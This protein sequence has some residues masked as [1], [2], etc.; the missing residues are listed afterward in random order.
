[1]DSPFAYDFSRVRIQDG[2]AASER[3]AGRAFEVSQPDDHAERA[4]EAAAEAVTAATTAA[5]RPD[6][7][8]RTPMRPGSTAAG[9]PAG[10]SAGLASHGAPLDAI[11]RDEMESKFGFDFGQVRV[12]TDS[13]AARSAAAVSARAYTVGRDVVFGADQ[14]APQTA[15]GQRLLAHELAHTVQQADGPPRLNR[16]V[17]PAALEQCVAELGGS[18]SY[19]DGGIAQ[20]EELERYRKECQRRLAPVAPA[21]SAIDNLL[22]AW[23]YAKPQLKPE[24]VKEVEN[25]FTRQSIAAMAAFAALYAGAQFTP[26]GWIAD[27]FALTLLT[28]TVI[29]VGAAAWDI[30]KE[31]S[32]FLS[33]VNATTDD[34]RREAGNALARALAKGGVAIFVALV[35]HTYKGVA[36][37]GPPTQ[38]AVVEVVAVNGARIRTA[39]TVGEAV[40]A[41]RAQKIA[42]YA[43]TVPP[44]GGHEPSSPQQSSSGGGS[45]GK[46]PAGREPASPEGGPGRVP[47]G[48]SLGRVGYGEGPMS[49]LAQ[50]LRLAQGLRRGGNVAVFEFDNLPQGFQKML[51]NLGGRNVSI[52]GNRVAFQNVA[53]AAHS[54]Q[55]A[56]QLITQGR[57]AGYTL[58]VRRIYTE[59]NPCSQSCL[60]LVRRQYPSAEVSYSFLWELWG[61]ETPD[62]NAAVERLFESNQR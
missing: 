31:L 30:L 34:E 45:G 44:P 10:V 28:L 60:P 46:E 17:D 23:E 11:I 3:S 50:R 42:S 62:R 38:T 20:P 13:T 16:D 49:R 32:T 27:A 18:P 39:V 56:H 1:M 5:V 37:P 12:H 47:G 48:F 53:G 51:T 35:A 36:R 33:V 57:K 22:Q 8:Q 55:L 40:E 14:Y 26:V 41:S 9:A 4:A 43:M 24:V 19:R 58:T 25:L 61:R 29:V 2:T 6:R 54:E 7:L 15:S 21:I 52:E 59:Y